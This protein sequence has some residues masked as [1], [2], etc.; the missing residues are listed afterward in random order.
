MMYVCAVIDS[1][2]PIIDRN[3]PYALCNVLF[4]FYVV[5]HLHDNY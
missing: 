3:E 2:V 4:L 5:Y 1:Y